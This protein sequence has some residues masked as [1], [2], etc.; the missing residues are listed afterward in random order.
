VLSASLAHRVIGVD[1]VTEKDRR[2]FLED[3]SLGDV[4][5][6]LAEVER[7][8][9]GIETQ[10]DLQCT[11]CQAV[12]AVDLPFQASFLLPTGKGSA[13]STRR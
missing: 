4:A 2:A 10:I 3:L 11:S 7:V 1:G 13:G 9:G 6:L 8:D 5:V 12:Q